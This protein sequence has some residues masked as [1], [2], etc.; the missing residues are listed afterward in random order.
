MIVPCFRENKCVE[1]RI[2]S[3]GLDLAKT[4]SHAGQPAVRT[5]T[6]G[7]PASRKSTKL[8]TDNDTQTSLQP[9]K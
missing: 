7:Q 6:S 8:V 2:C 4:G 3:P 1:A 9:N 5:P